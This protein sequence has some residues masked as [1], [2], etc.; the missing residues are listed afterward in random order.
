MDDFLGDLPPGQVHEDYRNRP[1]L[2]V[3]QQDL[4]DAFWLLCNGRQSGFDAQPILLADMD[5]MLRLNPAVQF[6][7]PIECVELWRM[8]DLTVTGY[9]AEQRKQREIR[10]QERASKN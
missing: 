1:F 7:E 3:W 2:E 4:L 8:M 9:W 6:Y 5:I 10:D